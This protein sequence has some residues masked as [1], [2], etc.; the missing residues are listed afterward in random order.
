MVG[1]V[2][3]TKPRFDKMQRILDVSARRRRAR[4]PLGAKQ[5]LA[6]FD[7]SSHSDQFRPDINIAARGFPPS[8][9]KNPFD[10]K[11]ARD[12]ICRK[13]LGLTR[14][15]DNTARRIDK[16]QIQWQQGILHPKCHRLH[17]LKHKQHTSVRCQPRAIHQTALA[18]FWC[19]CNFNGKALLDT[20]CIHD[21]NGA[22]G[23]LGSRN[24]RRSP[25]SAKRGENKKGR[26]QQ[27]AATRPDVMHTLQRQI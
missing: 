26:E 20:C 13:W 8:N 25:A 27:K 5:A 22:G 16:Q 19:V 4:R 14:D 9:L 12:Q 18:A 6:C 10:G 2:R 15:A 1:R 24:I 23:Q 7:Q 11:L 3:W 21:G 17:I